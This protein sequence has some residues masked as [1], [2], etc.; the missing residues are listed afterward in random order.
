[1]H[2]PTRA[3]A[4]HALECRPMAGGPNG[5]GSISKLL[6]CACG[7]AAC[8]AACRATCTADLLPGQLKP[9]GCSGLAC[10][11]PCRVVTANV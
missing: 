5:S 10:C 8:W 9:V 6:V 3:L 11:S 1:M 2:A 4:G 7:C